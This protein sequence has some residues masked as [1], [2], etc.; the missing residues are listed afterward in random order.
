MNR[1]DLHLRHGRGGFIVDEHSAM[2]VA[3]AAVGANPQIAAPVFSSERVLN[4]ASPS[5]F[6]NGRCAD[7]RPPQSGG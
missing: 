1:P 6:R 7:A 2:H 4:C 3:E 5:F